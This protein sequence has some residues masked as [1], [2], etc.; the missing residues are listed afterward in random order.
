MPVLLHAA[1]GAAAGRATARARTARL[2]VVLALLA[3]FPDVDG[4]GLFLGVP[5]QAPFGHRGALHSIAMGI[6]IAGLCSLDA[7]AWRLSRLRMFL[8]A[9]VVVA[10]H[11]V[12]DA[13]TDGGLG[14]ALTWP[15]SNHRYF[16]P[17][18]PIPVAPIGLPIFSS[19]GRHVLLFE[20]TLSLPLLAYALWPRHPQGE[21]G[22]KGRV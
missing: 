14:V 7:H 16:L 11:G 19:Y 22:S 18:R 8:V 3:L 2:M 12:L 6:L 5:Y 9:S 13:L 17:W 15:L 21:K 4:L 10:S 1:L 20:L